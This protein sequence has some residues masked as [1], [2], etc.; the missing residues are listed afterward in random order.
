MEEM[1]VPSVQPVY[2]CLK[3]LKQN[4]IHIEVTNLIVPKLGESEERLKDLAVWVHDELGEDT[5]MHLLRFHP[6][7]EL[8]DIPPTPASTIDRAIQIA[9]KTG[10]RYVYAGNLPGSEGENT[11]CPR[12]KNLLV[13]RCGF[14]ILKWNL[15]NSMK[16]SNCGEKIPIAGTYH[17]N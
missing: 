4:G 8:I 12:C 1:R 5:P 2:E 11:Y 15:T 17:P 7:Y 13:R 10:L 14:T 9:E 6:S 16:C 3:A